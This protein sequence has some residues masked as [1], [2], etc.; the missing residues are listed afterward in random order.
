MS[1]LKKML[2]TVEKAILENPYA[3][4]NIVKNDKQITVSISKKDKLKLSL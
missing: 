2:S 3:E 4:I 1:E